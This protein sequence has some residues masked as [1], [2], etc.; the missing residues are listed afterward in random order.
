M[1]H[2]NAVEAVVKSLNAEHAKGA[3]LRET[4]SVAAAFSETKLQD[5]KRMLA[6][7]EAAFPD[8]VGKWKII[9]A[10][11]AQKVPITHNGC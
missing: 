11:E 3:A 8:W 6:N 10:E 2:Y 1:L 7:F 5:M 4:T 9:G